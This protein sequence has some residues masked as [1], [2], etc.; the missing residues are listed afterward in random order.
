MDKADVSRLVGISTTVMV[1]RPDVKG[2]PV[3]T[4]SVGCVS[5]HYLRVVDATSRDR[6]WGSVDH[7]TRV[8]HNSKLVGVIPFYFYLNL[9]VCK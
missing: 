5:P 9:K 8:T 4:L 2:D 1:L 3:L 6:R 7:W